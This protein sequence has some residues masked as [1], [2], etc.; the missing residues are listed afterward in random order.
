MNPNSTRAL[1]KPFTAAILSALAPGLGQAHRGAIVPALAFA[2]GGAILG[3]LSTLAVVAG[4][5]STDVA[6]GF[7]V[8]WAVLWVL[9]I[10]DAW[11]R[12]R[13]PD[14]EPAPHEHGGWYIY[15]LL[16][17][18]AAASAG[19]FGVAVRQNVAQVFRVPSGS[20]L[21]SIS[22]GARVLVNELAYR[23]GSVQRG[24]V[25]VFVNPNERYQAH[26]KRVV[27]LPGDAV[28]MRDDELYVNGSRL[29]RTS[30]AGGVLWETNGSARYRIALETH[31]AGRQAP[32]SFGQL[33]V[34]NGH[35]F[36]LGDNRQQ[37]LDSR[38]YGPVPL[39]DIVGRVA[40]V[41]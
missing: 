25:I 28:E 6:L 18:L 36:V 11:R 12:A 3:M 21:P 27:A 40:R 24:D 34:P 26:I 14:G 4:P 7:A 37:S 22:P 2:A 10:A 38:S 1:R 5:A 19:S 9:G 35:C 20:M 16:A 33:T 13:S 23:T 32:A 31:P 8:A 39:S 15:A 30:E 41:W 29:E 17:L